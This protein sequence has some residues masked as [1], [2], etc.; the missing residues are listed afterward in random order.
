MFTPAPKPAPLSRDAVARRA[1]DLKPKQGGGRAL[2]DALRSRFEHAFGHDFSDVR[3]HAD[4]EAERLGARAFARGR[5][6]HFAAG[7]YDPA[8]VRGRRLLG[9]EIAHVAQQAEGAVGA[10]RGGLNDDPSL[11]T[12]AERASAALFAPGDGGA[13]PA[14]ATAAPPA[15]A[16]ASVAVQRVPVDWS[17][18]ALHANGAAGPAL[19]EHQRLASI[20][21]DTHVFESQA[22]YDHYLQT[23]DHSAARHL[24]GVTHS[25]FLSGIAAAQPKAQRRHDMFPFKART[26]NSGVLVDDNPQFSALSDQQLPTLPKDAFIFRSD[27]RREASGIR[28]VKRRRRRNAPSSADRWDL[29]LYQQGPAK[30]VAYNMRHD[31]ELTQSLFQFD[32]GTGPKKRKM[33][34]LEESEFPKWRAADEIETQG[35]RRKLNR[36]PNMTTLVQGH[37]QD[38]ERTMTQ[39]GEYSPQH[40]AA[41]SFIP[42]FG[43]VKGDSDNHPANFSPEHPVYGKNYRNTYL[44]RARDDAPGGSI[45]ETTGYH[46]REINVGALPPGIPRVRAPHKKRLALFA[47]DGALEREHEITQIEP[48]ADPT[49]KMK[50]AD[51]NAVA[52]AHSGKG[53][54]DVGMDELL[55]ATQLP[56]ATAPNPSFFAPGGGLDIGSWDTSHDDPAT[57]TLIAQH[58]GKPFRFLKPKDFGK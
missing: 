43:G 56:A 37:G 45:L 13:A 5:E 1:R 27:K 7:E 15:T 46:D 33:A 38:F 30:P 2:P 53:A 50:M 34:G 25:D 4:G 42:S 20:T 29:T 47:A 11:E 39:V 18:A 41:A 40:S 10:G 31:G 44:K 12:A 16:P 3:I 49:K 32:Q 24:P 28:K 55:T 21:T 17:G 54:D 36:D 48:E 51:Y 22:H 14:A 35:K 52:T 23:G 19:A 58:K 6:I 26:E 57:R 9:H 8:G